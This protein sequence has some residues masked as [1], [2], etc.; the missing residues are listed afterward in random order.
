MDCKYRPEKMRAFEGSRECR[1]RK[2]LR[3]FCDDYGIEK[4]SKECRER[5]I[6]TSKSAAQLSALAL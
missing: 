2:W 6:C 3:L 1:Y 5:D 4:Q